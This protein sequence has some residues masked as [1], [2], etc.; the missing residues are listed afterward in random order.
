VVAIVTVVVPPPATE[1]GLKVQVASEGKPEQAK[2]VVP[3]KPFTAVMVR[4]TFE[5]WPGA[6]LKV[7]AEAPIAKSGPIETGEDVDAT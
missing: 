4:V 2:V 1:A 5:F 7:V 3:A 6:R